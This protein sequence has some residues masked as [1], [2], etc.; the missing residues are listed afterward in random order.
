MNSD[1]SRGFG[2]LLGGIDLDIGHCESD[3]RSGA[4]ALQREADTLQVE[5]V[6]LVKELL[7]MLAE[8]QDRGGAGDP[9]RSEFR[10]C[11][12]RKPVRCGGCQP[13]PRRNP[14]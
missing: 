11:H 14:R 4:R 7:Q 1:Y 2:S 8:L 6:Q 13:A 12:D 5:I 9:L 10:M 3:S